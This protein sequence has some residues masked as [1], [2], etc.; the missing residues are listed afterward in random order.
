MRKKFDSFIYEKVSLQGLTM[1]E[2]LDKA[3][4][5][6]I[7]IPNGTA[8]GMRHDKFK[9]AKLENE[10][11]IININPDYTKNACYILVKDENGVP[12]SIIYNKNEKT[13][14]KI[15]ET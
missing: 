4:I 10:Y 12:F 3:K 7:L 8:F 14:F 6:D 9:V 1:Q 2:I 11:T 15:K 13:G 5:G